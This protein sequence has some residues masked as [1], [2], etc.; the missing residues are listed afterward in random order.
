MSEKDK[1]KKHY[2]NY[3]LLYRR[4]A[5]IIYDILSVTAAS[6]LALLLRYDMHVDAIPDEFILPVRNFLPLNIL[7]T[8]LIFSFQAI[9]SKSG[10][11][12]IYN[13]ELKLLPD[14][15]S[16]VI[17]GSLERQGVSVAGSVLLILPPILLFV[18][19]QSNVIE[20]MTSSGIKE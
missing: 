12:I 17:S 8:L 9:W 4:T 7:L 18:L 20:T 14:A 13:E 15:I 11:S 1:P 3:Q 2:F 16:Q 10:G 6:F 19:S 5:L